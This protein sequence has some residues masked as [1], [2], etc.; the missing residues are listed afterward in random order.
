MTKDRI[1]SKHILLAN[2]VFYVNL[3]K[4]TYFSVRIT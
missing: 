3:I 4:S 2:Q 1:D